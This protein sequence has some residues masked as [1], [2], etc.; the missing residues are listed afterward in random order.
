[1]GLIFQ[2]EA[3]WGSDAQ[4]GLSDH[5]CREC[6]QLL[7]TDVASV[8]MVLPGHH[9]YSAD[10]QVL[11]PERPPQHMK[12]ALEKQKNSKC[13][14][15]SKENLQGCCKGPCGWW[16]ASHSLRMVAS[17]L[18]WTQKCLS[19]ILGIRK[20]ENATGVRKHEKLTILKKYFI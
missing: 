4:E 12:T 17:P 6:L 8:H 9:T 10:E 2:S 14:L 7:G 15:L 18:F 13:R 3:Y 11:S 20:C 1:M 16:K 5:R 19:E